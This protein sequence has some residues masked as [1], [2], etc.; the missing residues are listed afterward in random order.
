MRHL[1][2]SSTTAS[3]SA[4]RRRSLSIRMVSILCGCGA[5][6][7]GTTA[8]AQAPGAAKALPP[9]EA[10]LW[11]TVGDQTLDQMRGGF[12]LGGGVV[13]SFGLARAVDI[14]GVLVTT[15]SFQIADVSKITAAQATALNKQISTLNLVQ[16][17]PGNSFQPTASSST[18]G[19]FVQ[20]TLNNTNI[21]TRTLINSTTNGMSLAKGINTAA[22]VRDS[23]LNSIGNR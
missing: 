20:N 9:D 22:T 3:G 12:D 17:G 18:V 7:A 11:R 23:L 10:A 6:C 21:Q 4:P 2:H 14:N 8:L 5:L 13:V 19:T 15:T 16:N 1:D